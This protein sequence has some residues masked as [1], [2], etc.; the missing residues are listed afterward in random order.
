MKAMNLLKTAGLCILTLA[1]TGL[2]AQAGVNVGYKVGKGVS[3]ESDDGK[4]KMNL[5]GRL[6]FR[7]T[8]NGNEA[9]PDNSTFAV[10]RGKIK[11]DGHVFNE[12]IR[13]GFQMNLA[14]RNANTGVAVLED[15]FVDYF[16]VSYFG[17]KV[18]QFKV[19]F[20][21]Q[22]LTSSGSQQFVDRSFATGIFNPGRDLGVNIHGNLFEKKA[23]YN[24]FLMN[25]DGANTIDTNQ[26]LMFGGRFEVVPLGEYKYSESDVEHSEEVN[27]GFGLGYLYNVRGTA[28]QSGTIPA[29]TKSSHGTFDAGL[30]YKG[31]SFQGMG[32]LSRTHEGAELTNW[33]YNGQAGYFI[34]PK[35]FEVA[36]KHGGVVFSDANRN[37]YEY[38]VGLNYFVFGHSLKFQTDYTYLQSVRGLDLNDHRVRAQMQV[39]F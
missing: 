21:F 20:L 27:L 38:A 4:Y 3:F 2:E 9:V 39:I 1:A 23:N 36:L 17:I 32:F 6:Q 7:Y 11:L 5:S 12:D 37:Q 13:F 30:K 14:T 15:F 28:Y 16:P 29:G 8:Y 10:Q 33:G 25:G 34:V 22:E 19:P 35:H 24:L 18:G 26:G 31:F